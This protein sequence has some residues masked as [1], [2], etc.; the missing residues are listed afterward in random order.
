MGMKEPSEPFY[1]EA[2]LYIAFGNV[3]FVASAAD[4]Y[5]DFCQTRQQW[6]ALNILK[7]S[8]IGEL[9]IVED[10]ME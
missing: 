8:L 2:R 6:Q 7:H 1:G 4:R 10:V 9:K 5:V 3:H